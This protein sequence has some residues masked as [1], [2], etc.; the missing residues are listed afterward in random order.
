[1]RLIVLLLALLLVVAAIAHSI[2]LILVFVFLSILYAVARS[3]ASRSIRQI[4]LRRSF[5]PRAFVGEELEVTLTL[6]NNGQ[7][8]V[9]Y[10]EL[11]ETVPLDLL[12]EPLGP[13]IFSLARRQEEST[14]YTLS[15]RQRGA[16]AIG[17]SQASLGDV[18]GLEQ[19]SLLAAESQEL[20]VYPRVAPLHRLGL[21]THSAL[22]ALPARNLLAEDP[23]WMIGIRDYQPG[24]SP[25]R[26][27]WRASARLARLSVKQY[28]PALARDTLL[29]LNLNPSDYGRQWQ[30]SI[31]QAVVVAASLANHIIVSENLPVGLALPAPDLVAG[32]QVHLRL[33]PR[34]GRSQLI[35]IL[36]ALARAH[37]IREASQ[38][39]ASL[40]H[41]VQ[42]QGSHL[43]WGTTV[44]VITGDVT[45]ELGDDLLLLMRRGHPAGVIA[46]HAG[47]A[48]TIGAAWPRSIPIHAVWTDQDL[49]ALA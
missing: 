48:A 37:H 24:D 32:E 30:E 14:R 40:H 34:A 2:L 4:E 49:A 29:C 35:A 33:P 3:W 44:I 21:P 7:L 11:Q 39:P 6:H 18:L 16:Y 43:R 38:R 19:R 10:L 46:V 1:M 36:E 28:Q 5:S 22:T 15:C 17:P 45:P 12:T 25:R 8:P 26:I 41:L 31:E 13:R 9:P 47:P 27:H 20:L 23:S 42:Q